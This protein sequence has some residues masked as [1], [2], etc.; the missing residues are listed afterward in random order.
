M[1]NNYDI[2]SIQDN[3]RVMTASLLIHGG[4][5]NVSVSKRLG[6]KQVSTTQNIY[7]HC[8]EEPDRRCADVMS[9]TV[10]KKLG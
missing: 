5:D 7:S 3:G 10:C 8:F 2:F 6:H 4:A 1:H 9:A